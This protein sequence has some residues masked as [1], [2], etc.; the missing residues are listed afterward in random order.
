M[1]VTVFPCGA[2]VNESEVSAIEQLKSQLQTAGGDDEWILL[3][4]LAFSVTHQ[5]QSD[6]I[7]IIAIG[8]PG[9]RV[10]EVKHWS[11]GWVDS[12][13]DLVE[14][15]CDKITNKAK[16]IGTTLRRIVADLGRVDGAMLLTQPPSKLKKVSGR[17][18]R[19]VAFYSLNKWKDVV[20]FDQ[21]SVLPL[22]QIRSLSHRLEP[23][24]T[25]AVDGSM[26]RLAGYVNLEIQTPREQ[27]VH[28][29]YKGSHHARRD[30][31]AFKKG[32]GT[33]QVP[34]P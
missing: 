28:R 31:V 6:E 7:D 20:G 16:K 29:V 32:A 11:A 30:R 9:V 15:E 3:T 13:A 17:Q 19:G 26:R 25:V 27:R 12:H 18:T 8:P 14:R 21:P 24:S 4:N 23:K 2:V 1:R 22:Q 34:L 33:G 10:I 5:F